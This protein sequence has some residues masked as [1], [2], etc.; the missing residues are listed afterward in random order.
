MRASAALGMA[1]VGG[2]KATADVSAERMH[3]CLLLQLLR[4]AAASDKKR[5]SVG[6]NAHG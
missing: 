4:G 2:R 3:Y 6:K 5:E 1:R